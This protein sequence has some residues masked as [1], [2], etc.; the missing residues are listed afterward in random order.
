MFIKGGL[1]K[2]SQTV[3]V[4]YFSITISMIQKSEEKVVQILRLTFVCFQKVG[5]LYSCQ[6]NGAE[7]AGAASTFFS[8]AGDAQ[9]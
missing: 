8:G 3:T 9:K 7:A 6:G 1:L 2:M 4:S 5:L